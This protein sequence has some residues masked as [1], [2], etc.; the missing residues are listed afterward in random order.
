MCII[1]MGVPFCVGWPSWIGCSSGDGSPTAAITGQGCRR[2]E[3]DTNP[4]VAST[5]SRL[6]DIVEIHIIG[7]AAADSKR[8]AV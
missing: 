4:V 5:E 8:T 3:Y 7:C 1:G 6:S 2:S